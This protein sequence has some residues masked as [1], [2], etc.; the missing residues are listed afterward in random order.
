M[1]LYSN[2]PLRKLL[3][4]CNFHVQEEIEVYPVTIQIVGLPHNLNSNT[5]TSLNNHHSA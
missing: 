3:I 5:F 1:P 4:T 2:L